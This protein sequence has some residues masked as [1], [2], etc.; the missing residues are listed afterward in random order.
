MGKDELFIVVLASVYEHVFAVWG[1]LGN[2]EVRGLSKF[3][4]KG[5]LYRGV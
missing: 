1:D 2:R 5:K 4:G 3:K